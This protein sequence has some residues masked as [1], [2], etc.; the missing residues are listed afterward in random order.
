MNVV[1][2]CYY[3]RYLRVNH[4]CLLWLSRW[5]F[6]F[7]R[8]VVLSFLRSVI[9]GWI[10]YLFLSFFCFLRE[11]GDSEWWIYWTLN[12]EFD[13]GAAIPVRLILNYIIKN[14][15]CDICNGTNKI[16]DDTFFNHLFFS[17]IF[18]KIIQYIQ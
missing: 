14:R 16:L 13:R 6:M 1:I 17:F 4:I 18:L 8:V 7:F 5:C 15:S 3:E 2:S 9:E 10:Q 11:G 12:F